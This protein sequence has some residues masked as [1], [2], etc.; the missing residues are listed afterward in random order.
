MRKTKKKQAGV[1]GLIIALVVVL[2]GGVL[3]VGAVSGWFDTKVS[4]DTEY[5][6]DEAK[7][8]DLNIDEYEELIKDKK[9]FIIFVDQ[10]GCNTADRLRG[11]MMDYMKQKGILVYWMMFSNVKE[12]SL[13]EFVKYYPSVVLVSRGKPLE[14][15]KADSDED[16]E[17]YNNYNKF[18]NWMNKYLVF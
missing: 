11:Y 1:L 12:S 5:Y 4:L 10:D 9:S 6:T 8:L 2:M 16:A 13:H 15:L 3:F 18:E 17:I 14:W 7:F